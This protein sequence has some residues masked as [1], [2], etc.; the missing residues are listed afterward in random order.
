M[1]QRERIL[2]IAETSM[3]ARG[4]NAVS[5]REIAGEIGIKSASLHYHFPKKADLGLELVKRYSEN[6]R[7]ALNSATENAANP[8]EKIE[9][10]I[11]LHRN[12]LIE[13][14]LLCLC[15][16]LGAEA[17]SLPEDVNS[18]VANFFQSNINWL[19]DAYQDAGFENAPSRAKAGVATLAGAL[20]AS[21]SLK[22]NSVFE[23][24]ADS[25]LK[26]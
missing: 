18:S 15:V 6:F 14:E 13:Q 23:A 2:D 11:D 16:V 12:A 5:F 19:T 3:R 20:I 10:F 1:S 22:D 26:S 7:T 21:D 8:I 24:A 4:Y 25:V 17:R 9:A